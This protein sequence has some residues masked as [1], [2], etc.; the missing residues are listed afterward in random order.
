MG[1]RVELD[2]LRGLLLVLMTVTHL[3]T[4]YSSHWGQPLGF[5]SA[6][7]GFVFVSAFLVGSVYGRMAREHGVAAMSR[8]VWYRAAKIYAAHAG[9]LLLLLLV[10]VPIAVHFGATAIT[11]LASFYLVHPRTALVAGL[12]LAYDP[13]LLDILP[14][15]VLFLAV[16]PFLVRAAGRWGYG[17]VLLGS[18]LIWLLAQLGAG[19]MLHH[20]LVDAAALPV[21]YAQTGAFSWLAWQ[22][23]WTL[24]LGA[25][26]AANGMAG[27][28]R[29][30]PSRVIAA[31]CIALVGLVWRHVDGQ[32]P[33][34]PPWL[35]DAFDKWHLGALRLLDFG[36]L[37]VL[38]VAAREV[39]RAAA[40]R[41]VLAVMGSESLPVFCVHLVICLAALVLVGD[42]A[43]A[44]LHWQD[45]AWLAAALAC[46][47]LTAGALRMGARMLVPRRTPPRAVLVPLSA[48]P[49]ARRAR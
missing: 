46:L 40:E 28:V 20:L 7:E 5:V 38:V 41:S 39:I 29:V 6:A 37:A 10:L 48:R 1:R 12:L 24:G 21:P 33:V 17:R 43:P 25:G 35:V 31:G 30:P 14:M 49:P 36:A 9:L 27:R 11:D 13:P 18:A 47:A 15:Y 16:S 2:W 3:P 23:L 44:T 8:R 26:M 22:F 19:P 4:W 42:T 45:S 32:V 34:G